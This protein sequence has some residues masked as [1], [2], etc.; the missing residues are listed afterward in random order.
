MFWVYSVILVI[1]SWHDIR[2]KRI[3]NSVN[4]LLAAIGTGHLIAIAGLQ[5]EIYLRS[6][7]CTVLVFVLLLVV[8]AIS[9]GGLG[10]GDIKL[11]SAL[12]IPTASLGVEQ[13][14]LAWFWVCLTTI[15]VGFAMLFQKI[16]WKS[17]IPFGPCLA[18][19]YLIALV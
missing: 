4:A 7:G 18:V 12:T 11:A 19:G 8:A 10:G 17:T 13:L 3:P 6:V 15:P 14:L 9:G 16:T 2:T 5:W 1:V